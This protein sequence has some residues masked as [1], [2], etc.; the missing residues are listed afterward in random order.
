M[1]ENVLGPDEKIIRQV[2]RH[3]ITLFPVFV[4][5]GLLLL[6]VAAGF[7]FVGRYPDRIT[8]V[9]PIY[10]VSL[11]LLALVLLIGIILILSLY[12]YSQ[13]SLILT[14]ENLIQ[15]K[16]IGIFNRKVSV[17]NLKHIEDVTGQVRGVLATA[18]GYGDVVVE[19]A[20]EQEN[21]IFTPVAS[22]YPIVELINR[23]H[24]EFEQSLSARNDH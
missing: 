2:K 10:V 6:A 3:P 4:G 16:Q 14:N 5:M 7:Y 18:L 13:S 1:D 12:V 19:T 24:Q 9:L 15:I 20:G 8:A 17:L 23:T 21:F 22:P 11:A